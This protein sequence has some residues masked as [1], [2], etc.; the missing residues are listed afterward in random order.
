MRSTWKIINEEIGKIKRD[1]GIHSIVKDNKFII[2]QNE[3][4]NVFN[5]YFLS[6]G[7]CYSRY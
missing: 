6:C 2:N 1:R 7:F 3:I 5:K 4:A